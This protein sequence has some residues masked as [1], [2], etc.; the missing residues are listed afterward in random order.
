MG[1]Q[2]VRLRRLEASGGPLRRD[3]VPEPAMHLQGTFALPSCRLP[4]PAAGLL[5]WPQ[6]RCIS[7]DPRM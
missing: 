6:L 2:W 1:L 3:R 5:L 7:A 4:L